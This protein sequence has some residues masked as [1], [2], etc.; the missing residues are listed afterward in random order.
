MAANTFGE[1]FRVTSFGESHGPG[2]GVVVDGVPAGLLLDLEAIQRELSRRRPGQSAQTTAR[3]EADL[4]EVLSGLFQGKTTGA[5]VALWIKNRDVRSADYES[6]QDLFRPG[7]ADYTWWRKFGFRDWRGGGRTSG[8]ET[9]ARVAAGAIGKQL[10]AR[11]GIRILGHVIRIGKVVAERFDEAEIERNP[12]RCADPDAARKMVEAIAEV[13]QQ[14]DSLGGV[15]EVIAEGVPAGWGDPVF[16]KLDARIGAA[17]FSLGAVKGVELGDGFALC[18]RRGSQTN[19]PILP[20]GLGSNHMGGTLGGIS[21]GAP[22]VVRLAVKPTPSIS[23]PQQ[24]ID[25]HGN[26]RTLSVPGRHDPCI[27]PRLVP[28][29]EAMLA[30]TLCDAWLRDRAFAQAVEPEPNP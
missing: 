6:I 23:L 25:E 12:V 18:D 29:A 21:S 30:L 8:R 4:L 27:C 9:A 16:D 14:G 2:I 24:T 22:L 28:V 26:P 3:D 5:P 10:L 7:H 19:D 20:G 13:M 11:Q 15:L 1:L 17:M